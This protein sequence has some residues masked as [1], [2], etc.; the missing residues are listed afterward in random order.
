[1]YLFDLFTLPLNL[2]GVCGMSLPG[3]LSSDTQLPTGLQLMGPAHG[4]ESLYRVG[5]AFEA[6]REN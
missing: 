3:G 5:S 1:M 4:E 6:G 2:A